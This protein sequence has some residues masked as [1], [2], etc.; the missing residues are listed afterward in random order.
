MAQIAAA[1]VELIYLRAFVLQ[2]QPEV[3]G[4]DQSS[5]A[6]RSYPVTNCLVLVGAAEMGL[7]VSTS[8]ALSVDNAHGFDHPSLD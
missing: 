5:V 2:K 4:K 6:K 3:S 7:D 8:W 1:V